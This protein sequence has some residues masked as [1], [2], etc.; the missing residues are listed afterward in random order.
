MRAR[1]ATRAARRRGLATCSARPRAPQPRPA[2]ATGRTLLR[3]PEPRP[4]RS[5]AGPDSTKNA[6]Y[7]SFLPASGAFGLEGEAALKRPRG[8]GRSSTRRRP[9]RDCDPAGGQPLE[10][11]RSLGRQEGG[12]RTRISR[13]QTQ[14]F[15][16]SV[17]VP[18]AS[19]RARALSLAAGVL[20]AALAWLVPAVARADESR[21]VLPDFSSVQFLGLTDGHTLLLVGMLVSL[22]GFV[23][24]VVMYSQIEKLPVHRSM[25]E[26]SELIYE[27]CK[28]YLFTQFKFILL[29]EVFIGII[30]VAYFGWLR[31]LE[32]SK[33]LVILLFIPSASA[34]PCF[35]GFAIG[36]SLGASAL[37][38]AGGIFTKIADIGSDL[39]K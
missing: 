17:G 5:P 35:I 27:T 13:R 30:I 6:R 15:G 39:M 22:V 34:G 12:G 19:R 8:T 7:V 29:L 37:R 24:G 10:S 21:I 14:V 25:R 16:E 36:E 23:F 11:V 33:V 26:I 20:A 2:P 28:T 38:I 18:R 4:A 32:A 1:P 31:G 9:A 3:P